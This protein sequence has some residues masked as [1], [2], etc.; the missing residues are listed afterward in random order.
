MSNEVV[1]DLETQNSFAQARS[2]SDGKLK[3][4]LVGIYSYAN[5][6]YQAYLESELTDLWPILEHADRIIGFNIHGFDFPVLQ[7]YYPGQLKK[8]NSLD[9]LDEIADELGFRVSLDSV[10]Q[11]TLTSAKTGDGLQAIKLWRE[12]RI[13]ELK[14]YCL[15]D[16]KLTQEIYEYGKKNGHL[17]Y[18]N[19][20]GAGEVKVNF[21]LLKER[22]QV[23]LTLPI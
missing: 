17:K 8:F 15:Q 3:I 21:S 13:D 14:E 10:A 18:I 1:L 4:S 6:S 9:I 16:V 7:P 5:D 23:N 12:N 11:G 19:K 22:H 2:T 20:L